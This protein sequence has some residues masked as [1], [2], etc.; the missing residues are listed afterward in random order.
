MRFVSLLLIAVSTLSAQTTPKRPKLVLAIVVDQFRYDY[1]VKFRDQYNAGLSRLLQQ[2]AVFTN[3][4][5]ESFPTVTA[6]GH[7]TFLSG[8]TPSVSG[9]VGNSWY[10]REAK[11]NVTSVSD[12]KETM[13]GGAGRGAAGDAASPRR[14]LVST[15]GDELKMAGRAA[16]VIGISIKDRSAI[17]PAGHMADGAYWF[18]PG[19]GNF[20]SSSYYFKALP[21][22]VEEFN[23]ARTADKYV[24]AEWKPIAGGAIFKTMASNPGKD[25]FTS[26]ESTPYGNDLLVKFS[27]AAIT[28]EKLGG[29]EGTDVLALS[30]S[31]NDYVGHAKGPDD[32]QVRDISIRTD[33]LLGELFRFVEDVVVGVGALLFDLDVGVGLGERRPELRVDLVIQLRR[34]LVGPHIPIGEPAAIVERH[35]LGAFRGRVDLD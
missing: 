22:W 26:L 1:L 33:R 13:L 3:A 7:S 21:P 34:G 5:Y 10:D 20:V 25:Y 35:H 9:I 19:S 12:A 23:K 27:E 18:D 29:H 17:L 30:L 15:V 28:H 24:A 11:R 32:P 6:I 2:G 8:A 4:Y 31:S 16:K 14:M